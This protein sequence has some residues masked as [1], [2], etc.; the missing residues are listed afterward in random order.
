MKARL[1]TAVSCLILSGL[2]TAAAQDASDRFYQA[3]RDNNLTSLAGL[4]KTEDV[5][6]K[7]K[8]GSTPLMYAAAYGSVDSMQALIAGGADVNAKNAFDATALLWSASDIGK[9]RLLV[10]HGADVNARSKPG[11][12]PLIVAAAHDGAS[13]IVKLLLDKGADASARDSSG[14]TALL[15][16]ADAN[17]TASVRLLVEKGVDVNARGSAINLGVNGQTALMSA[18]GHGNVEVIKLLLAKGADVNAAAVAE[19]LKV[20]NGPTAV[21]SLTPLLQAVAYGGAD[22][23]KLLLDAGAD[24]NAKD[25]RGM[26]PLMLAIASDRP[27]PRVVRLLLDK[28]ADTKIKSK[29]GES[30]TDW[31]KKYN[32]PAVLAALGIER[33]QTAVAPVL[34]AAADR[35][36]LTPHQAV[37]KSLAL[38]QRT[39]G[40]F[41]TEGGCVSCHAQNLTGMA[42]SAAR[43]NGFKVDEAAAAEQLK[44]LKLQ[45][46][47]FE[48]PLLQRMDPPGGVDQLMYAVLQFA[49]ERVPADRTIDALVFNIAGEQHNEGNWH[50]A[51]ISRSPMEDG[52]FSR[53][54]LAIRS[55]QLY[56][57]AGRKAEFDKRI[58]RGAAWLEHAAPRST[59]DRNMQLLGLKWAKGR[60]AEDRL[61]QLVA[62]QRS[63]GGW[64]QTPDLT[65]DAYAT[66]QV[67]YTL[68]ELGIPSTDAAYRRGIDYLLKTQLGD[69]SWHVTSRAVKFQPYFQSGFPHD[70]DQWI[71][72]A[73]T[74]WATISLSY[75]ASDS[76]LAQGF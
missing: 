10:A 74:A 49:A 7:D 13:E 11:R 17:D 40:S 22:A 45:W 34:A 38:L 64:A 39:G 69:G 19:A 25:V 16:A 43:A 54:A 6:T 67:L 72:A 8:R 55:L 56:T 57:P 28:G 53:T 31:A 42:A 68:H 36:P 32:S 51:A 76:K 5:N 73:A 2:V 63:D 47:S 48:Q 29:N 50:L 46:A 18:A 3:T 4:L 24:V 26:T 20:K 66:G 70:H 35:E 21:G 75:A 71:S 58:E 65:S 37:E 9:V 14:S 33:A 1:T 44:T 61:K 59:E 41:F 60:V 30:A 62:L 15:A 12:T 27:D 23:V 52:D